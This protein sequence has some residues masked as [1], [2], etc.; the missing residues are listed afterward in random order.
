MKNA[1]IVIVMLSFISVLAFD[2]CKKEE[3]FPVVPIISFKEFKK[4]ASDSATCS[5]NFTDGD[6]DIGLDQFDTIAPYNLASKYHYNLYLV[7]YYM[8]YTGAWKPYDTK[9]STPKIDTLQYPYRIPNL[10]QDGQKKSLEGEIRV[11]LNYP[12][13]PPDTVVHGFFKFKIVLIDRAL[14]ISNEV[15][16]GPIP[17]PL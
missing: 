4:F 11:R 10:T 6:G 8:D 14:H 16:T 5:I 12:Y 3:N 2:S 1:W 15:D 9:T 13:S 7:Y 17:Q